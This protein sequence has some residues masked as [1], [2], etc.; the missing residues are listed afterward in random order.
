LPVQRKE[1]PLDRACDQDQRISKNVGILKNIGGK[2]K[3][4]KM[5]TA[6]E[7][8]IKHLRYDVKK[9]MQVLQKFCE[10]E[11]GMDAGVQ[12]LSYQGQDLSVREFNIR[13]IRL[14]ENKILGATDKYRCIIFVD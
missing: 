12:L 11:A 8:K 4:G 6:R 9:L 7:L 13:E 1:Q 14:V 2:E 5:T 10:S 3:G